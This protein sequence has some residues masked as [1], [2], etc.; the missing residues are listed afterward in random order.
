MVETYRIPIR[1]M[2]AGTFALNTVIALAITLFG[3]HDSNHGFVVNFV[4]SQ[5]IGLITFALIDPPR[6]R[7]WPTRPSPVLP[8]VALVLVAAAVG[9]YAGALLAGLI[10][11]IP[12]P[13]T[14]GDSNGAFGFLALTIA[15]GLGVTAYFFTRERLAMSE[16]LAAE[17]RLKLLTA[18]IEP[19]FLFNTLA[20]LQA[21]IATDAGRAQTMLAHLDQY[22]RASLTAHRSASAT[23]AQEFAL[24]ADYL[25]IIAIRMGPR[26]RFTLDLPDALARHAVP[27]M[28]LQPLIE[29]AIRHGLEPKIAGG[30][31]RVTARQDGTQL[32]LTVT[33]SGMGLAPSAAATAGTGLG[34]A[35]VRE[36]LAANYGRAASVVLG[37]NPEGGTTVSLRLPL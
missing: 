6:R 1:H 12:S 14:A 22:L 31:V 35:H 9:W 16:R 27:P 4:F 29:N 25:E 13:H 20:N 2:F 21:L 30:Q 7:L 36:R 32:V 5:C 19:H 24:L 8:M 18:Q 28:L 11:G 34:I 10:L 3:Q 15:A 17:A 33:D 37:D 26:L 23:L